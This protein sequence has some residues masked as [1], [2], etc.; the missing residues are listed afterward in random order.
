[1]FIPVKYKKKN[2]KGFV[3]TIRISWQAGR[4]GRLSSTHKWLVL[5]TV[6]VGTRHGFHLG[7]AAE[8]G[9]WLQGCRWGL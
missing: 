2:E 1:M 4:L 8:E 3:Q 7:D 5:S 6:C 9:F